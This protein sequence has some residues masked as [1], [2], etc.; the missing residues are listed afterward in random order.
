M[1]LNNA[2]EGYDYQDLITSY[3][4]LKEALEG[5]LDCVFSIDKKNTTGSIPDRFDD[6]VIT[7]GI[8]IQR[9]QSL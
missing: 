4:V 1:A 6:L 9:K 3:F 7:N 2:H 8:H 5:N